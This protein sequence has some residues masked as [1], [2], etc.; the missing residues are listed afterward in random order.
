MTGQ[1]AITDDFRATL[2]QDAIQTV[3]SYMQS[4]YDASTTFTQPVYDSD[5]LL[6]ALDQQTGSGAV[7]NNRYYV[8]V[9]AD[10]SGQNFTP[11]TIY[12]P[13]EYDEVAALGDGKLVYEQKNGIRGHCRD[14]GGNWYSSGYTDTAIMFRDLVT[15]YEDAYEAKPSQTFAGYGG[16]QVVS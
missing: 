11:T 9:K 14:D 12:V 15:L 4:Q 5:C 16:A 2:Q 7:V 10:I 8:I 6:V 3:L 13:V 1:D